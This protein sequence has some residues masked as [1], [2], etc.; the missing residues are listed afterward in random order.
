MTPII[1]DIPRPTA[2]QRA[3]RPERKGAIV[4]P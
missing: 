1:R 4:D 3:G 2:A